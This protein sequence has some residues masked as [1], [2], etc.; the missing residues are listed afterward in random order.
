MKIQRTQNAVRNMKTGMILKMYQ[1]LCPFVL[2]TV[3]I[4]TLGMEYVGLNGLFSSILQ[5]LN[6]AELGV[7]A[8]LVYSMYAPIANDD[9]ITICALMKLYQRYYRIIGLVILVTG[10]S[11]TP[12]ISKLISGSIPDGINIYILYYVNLLTTVLSYWMFAYKNSLLQAHQR[13][14]I[15]NKITLLT[16]TIQYLIQALLLYAFRSYYLYIMVALSMQLVTNVSTACVVNRLYPNYK[17][18]GKLSE[19]KVRE[20][21]KKVKDIFTNK[22]G[23]VIVN[24]ADS[25]IISAF[26]GLEILAIYNNYYFILTSVIGIIAVSFNACTAGIGNSILTETSEKNYKDFRT[27]LFIIVWFVCFCGTCFLCLYQPFMLIW[28]GEKGLLD[29]SVV[30]CFCLYFAVYEI[31]QL[32]VTYKDA[33]GIWHADR[34]RPLITGLANL[35]LNL[36]LVNYI[37]LFGVLLSTV[38]STLFIGLPWIIN[39]LFSNLFKREKEKF[40]VCLM[41]YLVIDV[42]IISGSY[43]I[44]EKIVCLYGWTELVGKLLLCILIPNI[45]FWLIYRKTEEYINTTN[46]FKKIIHK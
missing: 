7:G 39:N 40:I 11:L 4:Y 31:N 15:S 35:L 1:M 23:G 22:I 10:V 20:I 27:Y 14:D 19:E 26:L 9:E 8:A 6:I 42:V 5:V 43:W 12:F 21:N 44:I 34:F 38:L 25:I 29:F 36:I 16:N 28:I 18:V 33:A 13:L 41:K 45:F 30:I 32:C 3:M 46:L 2:R 24:S 17:P 37:G